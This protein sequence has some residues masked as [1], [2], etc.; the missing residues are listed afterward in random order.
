MFPLLKNQSVGIMC[1]WKRAGIAWFWCEN[2]SYHTVQVR[3]NNFGPGPPTCKNLN[4]IIAWHC[5]RPRHHVVCLLIRRTSAARRSSIYLES[6]LLLASRNS[7]SSSKSKHP[8]SCTHNNKHP[9]E[10]SLSLPPTSLPSSAPP[11]HDIASFY[12]VKTPPW[13]LKPRNFGR[14]TNP[15][16]T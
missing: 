5:M 1:L 4:L 15:P 8:H 9:P 14:E 13:N 11:P 6:E 3:C 2:T 16:H 12:N 7:F 10:V